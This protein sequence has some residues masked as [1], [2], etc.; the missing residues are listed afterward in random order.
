MDHKRNARKAIS[1]LLPL[2][3]IAAGAM[4]LNSATIFTLNMLALIP[5][6]PWI[7]RSVDALSVGGQRATSELLKSSLGN[8]VELMVGINAIT[9]KRPHV[10][11]SVILGSVLS[12]LLLVLGSTL[13]ISGY[14][15]KRLRFD[16]TLTT[17]L[18]SLMTVVFILLAIPTI[19]DV[20][21]SATSTPMSQILLTQRITAVILITLLMTFLLFRLRTHAAMFAS[22]PF[23]QTDSN[24]NTA[25]S[26]H[27]HRQS[28]I[29]EAQLP[30]PYLRKDIAALILAAA[31]G[32][33]FG[34]TYYIVDSLSGLARMTGSNESFLAVTIVPI[35]GN[36]VKYHS[37][38]TG[39]RSYSQVE[40]GIR[41][42]INSV[43]RVTMLIAPLLVL[44]GWIFD[45]PLILRFDG[46]EATT[47]LLSVV[48]MTYLISDGRSNYFEGLM[49]IG[50]YAII[51]FSFYVRPEV[52]ANVIFL[53]S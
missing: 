15:K 18:S 21:P 44:V 39:S 32:G 31:S 3:G 5:L 29:I 27:Q 34:C 47:L 43:L 35:L 40:L 28:Q 45:R 48:V 1:V 30:R 7:S 8:S 38:V 52:P 2:T 24:A 13:F 10:S 51:A 53:G 12:N 25:R 20:F 36:F 16:R 41:A 4:R 14:D 33:T 19:M 22:T 6:G 37:I 42:I 26:R 46:F 11:Q 17:V 49:L 9:Q 50:T 23:A